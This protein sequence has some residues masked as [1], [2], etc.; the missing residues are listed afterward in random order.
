[1]ED[2]ELLQLSS[3][4]KVFYE[5]R[6]SAEE[7][8]SYSILKNE[9]F[10][11]QLAYRRKK[12]GKRPLKIEVSGDL[13]EFVK[14]FRVVH[15]P[16]NTPLHGD[17]C[18]DD[19]IM[20]TPG[21]APDALIPIDAENTYVFGE[22]W[23]SLWITVEPD[24]AVSAGNHKITVALSFEEE[25]GKK[26]TKSKTMF[27]EIIDAN[28]PEQSTIVTQWF[29]C[30]CIGSYFG[31]PMLSE[32][33]WEYID[34][35]VKCAAKNGIN[36]ILTPIFTPP[37]DTAIGSERPTVQ[38]VGVKKNGEKYI[39][40]FSKLDRW[41]DMCL[42]NGIRYFEMSHLFTQWGAKATPKIMAEVD[43]EEKRIFGWDVAS[44]SEAYKAFLS[45]FLP[46]ID[47]YLRKKGIADVT[48]FHISD[49]PHGEEARKTYLE[50]KHIVKEHLVGYKI[51]DALSEVE[52]F[53]EGVVELPVPANDHIKPFL[54]EDIVERW[55]YY[56]TC[57]AK[58]VSNRYMAMPSYRNRVIS[59]QMF[60]YG[61]KGFLHWGYNF[62]YAQLSKYSIN[63]Y[64]ITDADGAFQ[65]GDAFSVYPY[66]GGTAESLRLVVFHEA[67]Q[68][69]RAM[70]LLASKIGREAVVKL[71]ENEANMSV[72]FDKYPKS[73]DYILRRRQAINEKLKE[74]V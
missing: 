23:E 57:Q 65:S 7:L 18:D 5:T 14:V 40:D 31:V 52:F 33:H 16:V 70:E 22:R 10:S 29:H 54:E 74:F 60:K 64:V 38:L 59:D 43:G 63:P 35:F 49:E 71:F 46:E 21:L 51:M 32:A 13:A 68:D 24:K 36:M 17:N 69:I 42:G 8:F 27:L 73:A 4:E 34:K 53:R 50:V 47:S 6:P 20:K 55:T 12:H 37:L 67:L 56:C 58:D 48:Y 26:V 15:V 45:A 62:Y 41:V 1:M 2:I 44:T 66:N 3:L 19:Y 72:E 9:R 11:Y 30:D 25:D 61:I 28:L 39:F